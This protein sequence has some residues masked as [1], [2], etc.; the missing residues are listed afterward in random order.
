M[1][2]PTVRQDH[3]IKSTM[4]EIN[5]Q[6][7]GI[8]FVLDMNERLV[9]VVTDGDIRRAILSGTSL[10]ADIATIMNQDP[11]RGYESWG[12]EEFDIML[13]SQ[14]VARKTPK[15]G[16]LVVPILDEH[17]RIVRFDIASDGV[18]RPLTASSAELQNLGRPKRVLVLGGAGYIGSVLSRMLL[19]RG[20]K[21]K[22]MDSLIYGDDGITELYGSEDFELV[23][24]EVTNVVNIVEAFK[25]VDAVVHLAAIVGDPAGKTKP[26]QTLQVNYFSTSVL[27]DVAKYL[28]I[29]RFVFASTCSVYGFTVQTCK[30]TDQPNPL[31]LYAETKAM[32]EKAILDGSSPGLCSTILRF[33]TVY[34]LSPRMR[35]DL[36]V[37]LLVAKAMIDRR[38]TVFGKGTQRRPFVHVRDVARAILSTLEAPPDSVCGEIFNVGSEEQNMS[39]LE[40]AEAIN[41]DVKDAVLEKIEEKEDE[42]SYSVSFEKIRNRLDFTPSESISNAVREIQDFISKKRIED[43]EDKKYS[44]YLTLRES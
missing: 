40:L 16:A 23:R 25:D 41:E 19:E 3:S 12:K 14:S 34:G 42:R 39:I 24:G 44:N 18:I 30:E 13:S 27:V 7:I 17:D 43:Y 38:I 11:V 20:Y 1:N 15:I 31:S 8:A 9:G 29:T 36:V 35:F 37:N 28:G 22:V 32:S 26:K 33:A 21:V 10:Q 4:Q 2:V 5:K 6:G